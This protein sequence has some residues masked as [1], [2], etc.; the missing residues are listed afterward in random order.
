M[1]ARISSPLYYIKTCIPKVRTYT[2]RFKVILNNVYLDGGNMA[3]IVRVDTIAFLVVGLIIGGL[4]GYIGYSLLAP[5][6]TPGE[7]KTFYVVATL[8]Q[9]SLYDANFNRVS[10]IEVNKGDR[11]TLIFVPASF[12]PR[13][14]VEEL[15]GEYIEKAVKAGLLKSKEEFEG[16]KNEA[17]MTLAKTAYGAGFIPHG[18]AIRGYEDKVNVVSQGKPITV[19]FTADKVGEFDIYCSQF[20]GWGHTFMKLEKAFVVKG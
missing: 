6:P 5:T 9:F 10:K 20:C 3:S 4:A 2:E 19:T 17:R 11:V 7:A 15:E 12:I 13:G 1:K 16:Y 8:W 18:L 14:L